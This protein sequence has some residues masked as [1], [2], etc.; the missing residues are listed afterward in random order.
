MGLPEPLRGLLSPQAYAHTAQAVELVE[1]HISWVLLA[2]EF[3]YKIKRPVCYAFVDLRSAEHRKFLCEEEIRL[4]SRFAPELYLQTCAITLVAGEAHMGGSGE[5]IEFAVRMRRFDRHSALDQL[6][7]K[8]SIQPGPLQAFGRELALIHARLPTIDHSGGQAATPSD[9][10]RR[11]LQ[12]CAGAAEI[13]GDAQTVTALR[14]PIEAKLRE[15]DGWMAERRRS[16]KVKECHADLHAEN[17]IRWGGRLVAFDCLEFDPALRQIDVADEIAFL[18]SDLEARGRAPLGQAFLGGYLQESGD[19]EA[20]RH[21][22]LFKAHRALVRA[23]VMAL[24]AAELP[25]RPEAARLSLRQSYRARID[26]A[27]E[28]LCD[29]SPVLVLMSGLSG[30]G[31]SWLAQQL[32]PDLGAVHLRSDVERKRLANLPELASSGSALGEGLYSEESGVRVYRALARAADAT[33]QGGYPTIVDATFGRREDRRIFQNLASRRA[34]PLCVVWCQAPLGTLETRIA[35]RAR[36]GNDPSEADLSVLHWQQKHYEP[37]GSE[38][39]LIVFD[40]TSAERTP[41]RRLLEQINSL[42]LSCRG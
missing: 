11:N 9:I 5:A 33:L 31:K 20:C 12:E 32:A 18:L 13:F 1:T 37:I 19:Y 24:R 26:R 10:I 22:P 2:G 6:L 21:L 17:V 15:A 3:A 7:E 39:S 4:N 42:R 34:V 27:R 38:E 25:A 28:Y 29:A 41:R 35:E 14:E 8:G 23:K 40:V 36:I 30:S 16:G